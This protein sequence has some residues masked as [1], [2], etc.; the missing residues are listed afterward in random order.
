MK[1]L[2]KYNWILTGLLCIGTL[3]GCEKSD[4][5]KDA[6]DLSVRLAA[7]EATVA[8]GKIAVG[9]TFS[10]FDRLDY[11][12]VCRIAGEEVTVRPYP[13][14]KLA[15]QYT[16]VYEVSDDAPYPFTLEFVVVGRDGSRTKAETLTVRKPT[17]EVTVALS[18]ERVRPDASGNFSVTVSLSDPARTDR[19]EIE[20]EAIGLHRTVGPES[21][22]EAGYTFR[23]TLS[24]DE[25]DY[26]SVRFTAFDRG[27]PSD[28]RTLLVDRRGGLSFT[29]LKCVSRITGAEVNGVNGLPAVEFEAA[30]RT[31]ERFNVG[32]TDLGIV[33]EIR[34][35]RYGLFF[36]DTFGRDFYPN[37]ANPGPN[38]GSWRSNVLLFSDDT[39]LSDGLTIDGA[40][41]D[42]SGR[43]AREI[44]YGG[45]DG[46]G[47]G[48]WTSI[49]T[50]A[51]RA[52][53]ADY[54]HYMNIRNWAG[55]VTNYSS[56]YKST[57]DGATWT[58]CRDVKF[59][60]ES[61]F[62]Q[63]GYFKKDGYVY[64]VGTVTGRDHEPHLARFREHEIENR[65]AYEFWNGTAWIRGD[66]SAAQSL[67]H[68]PA[69]ELSVAY[70]PK[71]GK[72]VLLYFNGPRYEISFRTA[73]EITGP[74][75]EPEKLVDG[76]QYAQLYGSFIHPLSLTG[77]T[78]YFTMS[79]WLPY[80][81]YLMSVRLVRR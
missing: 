72:W 26:F 39:D 38:G 7:S 57:D 16:F 64:M 69:G 25:S 21:W 32:G 68:D 61:N 75:S 33:W 48:D 8:D 3:A 46:S 24:D 2:R 37:F 43:E 19:L 60:S 34:P 41:L 66:E 47:N 9:L 50:A 76:R 35:G 51:V 27:G 74:W 11:L 58:R 63:V 30:N 1:T 36:G 17:G 53:G 79:M 71:F 78:L 56:L 20:A 44:C 18:Q 13:Q 14:A 52:A 65:A 77:D 31:H 42:A 54:V 5:E 40:A 29:G 62:G 23:Y 4:S 81:S 49:P 22:A 80:N 45:K 73:D 55:W 15:P 59:G 67:F 6:G 10:G 70:H 12:E 28:S